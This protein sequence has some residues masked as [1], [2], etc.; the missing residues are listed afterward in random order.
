MLK[1]AHLGIEM[2]SSLARAVKDERWSEAERVL[3][4]LRV[5]LDGIADALSEKVRS[6]LNVPRPD[7]RDRG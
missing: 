7:E 3:Q 4:E 1:D 5:T 2:M 6:E